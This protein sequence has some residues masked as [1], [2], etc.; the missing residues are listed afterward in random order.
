[1]HRTIAGITRYSNN[2]YISA[3]VFTQLRR[4][5]GTEEGRLF[6]LTK[7][8]VCEAVDYL[9]FLPEGAS[10]PCF[11]QGCESTEL[12][13]YELLHI[14]TRCSYAQRTCCLQSHYYAWTSL[15]VTGRSSR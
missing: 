3:G 12:H 10:S 9:P 1:M 14:T 11:F 8:Q 6:V 5:R 13:L 7:D 15:D 4:G 2:S